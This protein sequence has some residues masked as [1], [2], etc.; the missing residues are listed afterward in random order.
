MFPHLKARRTTLPD[1]VKPW[2]LRDCLRDAIRILEESHALA[3]R[4][5]R[6]TALR[7]SALRDLQRLKRAGKIG[8]YTAVL[9][10]VEILALVRRTPTLLLCHRCLPSTAVFLLWC[11]QAEVPWERALRGQLVEKDYAGFTAAAARLA[12]SPL[13]VC[14]ARSAPSGLR[15]VEGMPPE[16]RVKAVV[17][18]W[19]QNRRSLEQLRSA[20]RRLDL[21][22]FAP[23]TL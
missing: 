16:E 6:M 5:E 9:R 8:E 20:A 21:V 2:E 10:A 17:C 12:G 1:P 14:E 11:E 7:Y 4:R 13:R 15:H 3:T 19:R 23:G 18:D 22:A